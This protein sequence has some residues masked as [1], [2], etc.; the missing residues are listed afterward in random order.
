VAGCGRRIPAL[1]GLADVDLAIT[2]STN[3]LPIRRLDLAV[4][5]SA[6]VDAVWV[7]LP[8]LSIEGLSQRYT[9][10]GDRRYQ[11]DAF[12][13]SFVAELEVDDDGVMVW[14][15]DLWKRVAPA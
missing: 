3:T 13:G 4:G 1:D 6:E 5:S 10:L 9:R 15:G 7:R 11:Y 8:E 14:Y 12:G 2:P